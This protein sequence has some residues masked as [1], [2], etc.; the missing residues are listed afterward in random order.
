MKSYKNSSFFKLVF[1]F[2]IPFFIIIFFIET[3]FS[4]IKNTS[5]TVMLQQYF[6]K[7]NWIFF[8]ERLIIM[9]FF[10]GLFMAGYYK[11]IKRN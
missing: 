4:V 5:F 11:F 8:F 6:Y 10:Y 3:I 7:G 2:G 9:A 1:Q